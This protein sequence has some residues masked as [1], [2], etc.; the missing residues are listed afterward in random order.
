MNLRQIIACLGLVGSLLWAADAHAG[1]TDIDTSPLA[2]ETSDTSVLPN[3]MFVLDDSGS[4]AFEY[5]PDYVQDG[6]CRMTGA[7]LSSSNYGGTFTLAC[8]PQSASDTTGHASNACW[9]GAPS[10]GSYRGQPPFL[11]SDFNGMAYNPAI[12]YTPPVNAD[13]SSKPSQTS[14]NT[15]G[16]TSVYNDAYRVENYYTIN[17]LTQFPDVE[18]CTST[19]YTDCLRNDNYVLPGT[20]NGKSYTYFHATTATGTGSVATGAPDAATTASRTFGPYYYHITP[21]EYCDN[22]NLRN[23][24]TSQGGAYT[25]AAP[26]RWCKTQAYASAA[27]PP[28]GACQALQNSTYSYVRYPTMYYTGGSVGTATTP[29][30]ASF[31]VS[32][33]GCG[34][35]GSGRNR[36]TYY[37][38]ATQVL[39]NGTNLLSGTTASETSSSS[40]ASDIAANINAKTGT[41]G[42]SATYSG[43]LVTISAPVSA[44]NVTYTVS[45]SWGSTSSSVCSLSISP[46]TPRFSGYAAGVGGSAATFYGSF[47][48]VDIVPGQTYTKASTRTDC[49]GASCTYDEEMTNFANWWTYYHS[50]M[51][52]MKSSAG[53]AFNSLS[54]RYRLGYMSINN[55]TGSDFLNLGQFTGTQKTNWYTKLY[56]ASPGSSTPLRSALSKVGR[57]YAGKMTSINNVSVTDPVQYSC[58]KNYTLLSTD[59]YWNETTTPTRVDGTTAIGDQDSSL[60]RPMFDG[61]ST[62]NTLADVAAYYYYTDLRDSTLSNCTGALGSSGGSVCDNN[63]S[64]STSDPLTTQHMTTYT[65]GLGNSGYMQFRSDYATVST[66][67]YYSV[68]NGLTA[69]AASGTCTWL[70][71]GNTCNWPKPVSNTLTAVDDLWHAAVNGH[72]TYFSAS[73]PATLYSGIN[74]ALQA[75][76]AE[77]GAAAAATASNPNVSQGDNYVF[78]SDYKTVEWSGELKAETLDITTGQLVTTDTW[79]TSAQSQLDSL[80]YTARKIYTLPAAGTTPRVLNWNN[81]TTTE[82]AYFK[83]G[84]IDLSGQALTQFCS[85]GSACL[86]SSAQSDAA[87]QK[88]LNFLLGDRS[89]E[90]TLTDTSKYFRQRT[91]VLG[92]IVDSQAVYVQHAMYDYSDS[93]Y[94]SYKTTVASRQ[95]MVYVGANDGML[96]AFNASTGAEAWAYV[97]E[98]LFPSLYKLADKDYADKHTYYVDATPVA[99]DVYFS[100]DSSWHTI[101]VGGLGE[102]GRAYYALDVTDPANPKVLWE[103]TD[104]NLGYTFGKPE[105]GKLSDG[106]WAVIVSSGYNNVSPGNGHGILYVINAATGAMIRSI[107]TAAG[108]TGTP[109]GLTGIRA[110]VDDPDTNDLILRV[111]GGDN[112]GNVWRFDVNGNVGV[113]GYDA[114]ILATLRAPD[115]TAQ[116]VTARPE[117]GEVSTGT[118]YVD[119][120]YVGTGRYLGLTDLTDTEVQ[121]IYAIKDPLYTSSW[122]GWGNP[123]A[124]STPFIQQTL[125]DSTCPSGSSYC[126]PGQTVRTGS[127]NAVDLSVDAGWYVDLPKSGER[128]NTDPTLVL[129]TLVFT[130]NIVHASTC[131]AG[132]SS[133]INFFDY[134]SGAPITPTSTGDGSS[135]S[136]TVVSVLLGSAIATQPTVVKLPGGTVESLTRMSNNTTSVN[137]VPIPP[138]SSTTRRVQWRE[139]N[140]DTQ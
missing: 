25:I 39:V 40:V 58:Q 90:G 101:L 56:A 106:T 4:M 125:T 11:S 22:V 15:S 16:W 13:G 5:L 134:R 84:Y 49:A 86:S 32:L 116:P 64:P 3:L 117:L 67:D 93:G 37:A 87:G 107:D 7:G 132:G 46:T 71:D 140:S 57:M 28:S 128:A 100:S 91:H 74:S 47:K 83:L 89:N 76:S 30:T 50:R 123:R 19:A 70:T 118:G 78:I 59:G 73:N 24:S 80:A 21:G 96:H 62:S 9:V 122:S 135:Q 34:T 97:P 44:G 95:G 60:S 110:W 126:S 98:A 52:M 82:Q 36:T 113:S 68:A 55:R 133:Y 85:G 138:S 88:L 127:S 112:L 51:Q 2:T 104:T 38:W 94:S 69:N 35:Y 130:T 102:G 119:V 79:T 1:L 114:Q 17:L 103:F 42:Y 45:V 108:S 26:V 75:I 14:A 124:S 81:L 41:T 54:D 29:A 18:W 77:T 66:G 12:T 137:D 115:G 8:C 129:G 61:T 109:S 23:C 136:N 31:T 105:I 92:D 111:Y 120:V 72:G 131:E 48:R 139:L 10:F 20:V 6:Y 27:N 65:L 53:I 43:S 63:V 99:A 33:S 121:S